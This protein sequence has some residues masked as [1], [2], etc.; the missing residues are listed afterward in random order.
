M[1]WNNKVVWSEGM[2]LKPQHFQQFDR[3]VEK[4]VRGRSDGLRPYPWG[5]QA[6]QIN[7]DLLTTGKFALNSCRGVLPDGTPFN[8]PDDADH[9][10]PLELPENTRGCIVY[11]ALPERQAG[12]AEFR[13]DDGDDAIARFR[14]QE[15]E[16][17]DS[18][19]GSESVASLQV[20]KL[21]F[22]YKLET[23]ERAGFVCLGLVRINEVRSDKNVVL[24]D[25]Y[26]VPAMD[27]AANSILSGYISEL[28]GLV[29][30][31]GEAL[32]GRVTD[33]GTK[34]VA[35][36]ADFLLLQVV[37]RYEPLL[38]HLVSVSNL[39]PESLYRF[40]LEL[41]GE[42]ATFTAANKRPGSFAVYRHED[43][44]ASF[45]PVM[46]A[47]RQALSA[48]LEQTAIP[49]PLQARRYGIHVGTISD[50][51]LIANATFVLAVGADLA[52]EVLRRNFPHQA[53]I[54]TVEDIRELVTVALPGI[55]LRP[56]PVAPR[57]IPYHAGVTYFEM[58][59]SSQYWKKLTT[60][61][62]LAIHIGGDFPGLKMECWAIK[63]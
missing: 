12:S 26:I 4:L 17:V 21:S 31:R 34:G 10:P 32:A 58:D 13:L 47:L 62:G 7:K 22:R 8:I 38:A 1:S 28:H 35:E 51:T 29:H 11:L 16:T 52:P 55:A 6:L 36:I 60:S 5:I 23:D 41:A 45:A 19:L 57:Q 18:N 46:L 54:G 24:D 42:L 37:N 2:F 40:C 25:R 33:S 56:L 53:K 48:V 9:P 14:Q 50:K 61:G 27:C 63:G 15:V 43:L 39:H 49:I 20:G 30:H 3:Y 59:R 44:Q